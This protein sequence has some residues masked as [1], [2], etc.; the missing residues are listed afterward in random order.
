RFPSQVRAQEVGR[1]VAVARYF[2]PTN[3]GACWPR[4]PT[5]QNRLN[6]GMIAQA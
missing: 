2:A 6:Y 3:R 4:Q 5:I 1:R